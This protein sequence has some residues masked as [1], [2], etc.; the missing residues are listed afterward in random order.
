MKLKYQLWKCIHKN[1][2]HSAS[3]VCLWTGKGRCWEYS[4]GQLIFFF[5]FFILAKTDMGIFYPILPKETVHFPQSSESPQA[6]H[7]FAQIILCWKTKILH[8]RIFKLKQNCFLFLNQITTYPLSSHRISSQLNCRSLA[9]WVAHLPAA[10]L[11]TSFAMW[12]PLP[13]CSTDVT[14]HG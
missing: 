8:W 1:I 11:A 7:D 3:S 2:K 14:C 9:V 5:L 6:I 12:L 13:L 4:V 10:G